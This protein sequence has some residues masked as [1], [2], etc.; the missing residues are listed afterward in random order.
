M[1][2]YLSFLLCISS[3]KHANSTQYLAHTRVYVK[4]M[5]GDAVDGVDKITAGAV[6]TRPI[7]RSLVSL[8][9]IC[10]C[11]VPAMT[12]STHVYMHWSAGCLFIGQ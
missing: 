9:C 8:S 2:I 7:G 4:C 6:D 3:A 12:V 11:S 10:V 1:L 5:P